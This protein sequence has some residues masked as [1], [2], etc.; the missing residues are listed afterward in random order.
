MGSIEQNFRTT[1]KNILWVNTCMYVFWLIVTQ[2]EVA[3]YKRM[4]KRD[5]IGFIDTW[6]GAVGT[7]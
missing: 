6:R 7:G 3:W 5:G 1:V 2:Q 4:R